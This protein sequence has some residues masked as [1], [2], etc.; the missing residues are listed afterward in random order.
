MSGLFKLLNTVMEQSG[1]SGDLPF[2]L[3]ELG[4]LL[5]VPLLSI[6]KTWIDESHAEYRARITPKGE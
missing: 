5:N 1:N 3:D 4:K 6:D 2:S